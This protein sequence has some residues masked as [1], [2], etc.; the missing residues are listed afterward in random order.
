VV[1]KDEG[2]IV[3]LLFNVIIIIRRPAIVEGFI[4]IMA[5]FYL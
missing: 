3:L 4:Y 1:V 2:I 5:G